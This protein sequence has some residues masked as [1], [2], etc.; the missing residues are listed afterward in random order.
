MPAL[1]PQRQVLD[2]EKALDGAVFAEST[3]QYREDDVNGGFLDQFHPLTGVEVYPSAFVE[4]C[5][6]AKVIFIFFF[7]APED[8][9]TGQP[10]AIIIDADLVHFVFFGVDGIDYRAGRHKRNCMLART[11]A[12]DKEQG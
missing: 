7:K 2:G 12:E 3:V 6:R 8:V 1:H 9:S 11:A 5:G 10:L 4:Q